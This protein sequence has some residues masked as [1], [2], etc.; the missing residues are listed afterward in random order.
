MVCSTSAGSAQRRQLHQPDAIGELR[1]DLSRQL[2]RQPGFAGAA[3]ADEREQVG[4]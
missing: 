4:V 2:Q 3:G 1:K